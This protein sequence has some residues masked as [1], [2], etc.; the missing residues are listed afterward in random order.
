ML[1]LVSNNDQTEFSQITQNINGNAITITTNYVPAHEV[2]FTK[3][4]ITITSDEIHEP[5]K[6][7]EILN[8]YDEVIQ[9]M[10]EDHDYI[11]NHEKCSRL[12]AF[13]SP[14]MSDCGWKIKVEYS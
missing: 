7:L 3:T 10:P 2:T 9:L 12:L 11:M 8:D 1:R 6:L 13:G 4:A 14:Q 5:H